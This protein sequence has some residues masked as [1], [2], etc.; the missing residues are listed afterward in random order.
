MTPLKRCWHATGTFPN[1]GCS[2]TG[3]KDGRLT[4][5]CV[6]QTR[7]CESADVD[8]DVVAG[9]VDVVL[10]VTEYNEKAEKLRCCIH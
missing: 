6:E 5:S 9:D 10:G 8:M 4:F 1:Q 3:A 2:L 7:K